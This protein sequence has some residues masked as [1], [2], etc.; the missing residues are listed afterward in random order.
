MLAVLAGIALIII[1]VVTW[2]G[3]LTVTHALALFIGIIGVLLLA[4]WAY[5]AG[6]GRRA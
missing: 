4:Y 1:G 6:W 5:P 3:D 2:L